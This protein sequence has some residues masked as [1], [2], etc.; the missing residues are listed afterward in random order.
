LKPPIENSIFSYRGFKNAFIFGIFGISIICHIY[1]DLLL[2]LFYYLY[3]HFLMKKKIKTNNRNAKNAK[4]EGI[5]ET[6][7]RE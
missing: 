1:L 6:P 3:I 5:F 2:L 4:N 7:Y